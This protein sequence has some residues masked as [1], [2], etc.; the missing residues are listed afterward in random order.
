[1]TKKVGMLRARHASRGLMVQLRNNNSKPKDMV[2]NVTPRGMASSFLDIN[3]TP[4]T[5][6]ATSTNPLRAV[7]TRLTEETDNLPFPREYD[8]LAPPPNKGAAGF[9]SMAVEQTV[10]HEKYEH[11]T[12]LQGARPHEWYSGKHPLDMD[13]TEGVHRALNRSFVSSLPLLNLDSCTRRDV[14]R[15]FDNT[16]TMTDVLFASLQGEDTF[17]RL[18]DHNLRHPMI[19]Y[20]GHVSVFYMNKLRKA[21]ILEKCKELGMKFP[22]NHHFE[23]VFAVGVDEMS[24]DDMEKNHMEWP[25]VHDV[26]AYRKEVYEFVRELIQ[27]HPDLSDNDVPKAKLDDQHPLWSLWMALEHDKIHL[28]TSSVLIQELPESLVRFPE[29]WPPYH[30]SAT[31][32]GNADSTDEKKGCVKDIN[33]TVGQDYPK[34]TMLPV[35][36]QSTTVGKPRDYPSF[37]WDNEYGELNMPLTVGDESK[38]LQASEFLVSNGEY[39]EFVQDDGYDNR[40]YWSKDGWQWKSFVGAKMPKFWSF[41]ETSNTMELRVLFDK[42]E[43][44]WDWPVT[45]NRMEAQAFVQWKSA[46]SESEQYFLNTEPVHNALRGHEGMEDPVMEARTGRMSDEPA[47]VAANLNLSFS[48]HSPVNEYADK[49]ES[50]DRS[51]ADVYGNSWEWCEDNMSPLPNGF[52]VHD[53][54]DDFTMPCFDGEHY[55]IMGGSFIS[56]GGNGAGRFNRYHFRPHFHQHASLRYVSLPKPTK[57]TNE[58]Q[59]GG[60]YTPSPLL[61]TCLYS[62]GPFAEHKSGPGSPYRTSPSTRNP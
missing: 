37:G 4:S 28:E 43:M 46:T 24:W 30:P 6:F 12:W 53:Y 15:Y 35:T 23:D 39:L 11:D 26:L 10:D 19:F 2:K 40:E 51:H 34:N 60:E 32:I 3:L 22:E 49:T 42:I 27:I 8:N 25:R 16:W 59:K 38:S 36:K 41:D 20:Y 50:S 33:L 29:F 14:L 5:S 45:L 31:S 17:L 56:C 44:Q 52:E 55:I 57:S 61:T 7:R 21:G 13:E 54:Y 9:S 47:G 48:S 62:Q 1:M 58:L 18:P